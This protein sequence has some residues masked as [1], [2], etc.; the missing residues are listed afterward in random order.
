[1]DVLSKVN[2]CFS[3]VRIRYISRRLNFI[4]VVSEDTNVWRVG[5]V[6]NYYWANTEEL[7]S[8]IFWVALQNPED[9]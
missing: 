7:S 2:E 9:A 6:I 5:N 4:L 8:N 1:M 3:K